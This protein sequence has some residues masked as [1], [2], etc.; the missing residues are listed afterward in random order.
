MSIVSRVLDIIEYK[1]IN[2]SKFYRETG[3]SNGFLDKVKD[4]GASKVENILKTYTDINPN[5][6]LTGEGEMFVKKEERTISKFEG[7]SIEEI[8][9]EKVFIKMK[10]YLD[11]KF[12]NLETEMESIIKS[13]GNL[14]LEVD[15]LVEKYDEQNNNA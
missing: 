7:K 6:L 15:D 3:L 14:H 2:K 9:A 5:W 4:I 11:Y 1:K 10:K 12:V 8:I 13:L